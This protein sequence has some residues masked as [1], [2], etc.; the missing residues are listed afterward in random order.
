MI[1]ASLKTV[2]K[3]HGS[4][5]GTSPAAMRLMTDSCRR[6]IGRGPRDV[7]DDGRECEAIFVVIR[8][9]SAAQNC[10][11]VAARDRGGTKMRHADVTE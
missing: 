7:G 2:H 4:M 5:L 1:C 11:A 10:A 6:R 9:R 3:F 8:C